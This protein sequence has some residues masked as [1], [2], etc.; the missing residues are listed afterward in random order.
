MT[1]LITAVTM[2]AL[3]YRAGR[4]HAAWH[5]VRTAKRAVVANRRRAWRHTV[6]MVAGAAALTATL[7]AIAFQAAR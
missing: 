4:T 6:Q 3:G 1:S 7:A 2:L 5:D